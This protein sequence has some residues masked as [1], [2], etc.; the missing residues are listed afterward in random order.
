MYRELVDKW[1][2]LA[3]KGVVAIIL[4]IILI[5]Y[6]VKTQV[7][8]TWIIGFFALIEGLLVSL[9]AIIKHKKFENWGLILIRGIFGILLGV[10]LFAWPGLSLAVILFLTGLWLLVVGIVLIF[11]A[12][13]L[14]KEDVGEWLIA[15]LGIIL[16]LFG[17]FIIKN[18]ELSLSIIGVV[19]GLMML[20]NGIVNVAFSFQLKGEKKK[21]T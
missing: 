3:I 5:S 14:R 12:I 1:W 21:I 13:A 16:I 4:G 10:I 19:L 17:L 6:P 2:L 15:A 9:I 8:I 20:L 18:P 11:E 7:V